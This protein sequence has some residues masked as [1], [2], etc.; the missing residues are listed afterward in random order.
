MAKYIQPTTQIQHI[1]RC[2]ECDELVAISGLEKGNMPNVL[3]ATTIYN[4]KI[5]GR[6]NAVQ[7]LRFPF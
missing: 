1:A 4:P 6:L 7:L 2:G 3:A 5:V